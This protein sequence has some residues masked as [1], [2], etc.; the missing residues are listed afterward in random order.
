MRPDAT[1]TIDAIETR[2][3][4]GLHRATP[5]GVL[6]TLLALAMLASPAR[7]QELG[8]RVLHLGADSQYFVFVGGAIAL[9]PWRGDLVL[10]GGVPDAQGVA[11][12]GGWGLLSVDVLAGVQGRI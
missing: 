4:P 11:T 5:P 7:G 1:E 10:Q 6:A 2:H 3:R 8:S 12:V 9:G